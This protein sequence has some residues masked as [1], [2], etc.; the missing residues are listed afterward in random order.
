MGCQTGPPGYYP[1]EDP[2]VEV[3][4]STRP[5]GR[6][7]QFF[8]HHRQPQSTSMSD[9][10]NTSLI[11][12]DVC[13]A[14]ESLLEPCTHGSMPSR[15]DPGP[16]KATLSIGE[17][18]ALKS[19]LIKLQSTLLPSLRQRLADLLTSLDVSNSLKDPQPNLRAALEIISQ[20][21][22]IPKQ[23]RSSVRA[24]SPMLIP[25]QA[26]NRQD[27]DHGIA[28]SYRTKPFLEYLDWLMGCPLYKILWRHLERIR[29]WKGPNQEGVDM[30][31]D[32]NL[33][34]QTIDYFE[35]IDKALQLLNRSDFGVLQDNWKKTMHQYDTGLAKLINHI[36]I[37]SDQDRDPADKNLSD[38]T[39]AS[40]GPPNGQL[41]I[42]RPHYITLL[43]SAIPFV[44]LG[45]IFLNKLLSTPTSRP[46]F[47]IKSRISSME[48]DYLRQKIYMFSC[49]MW[50]FAKTLVGLSDSDS[51]YRAIFALEDELEGAVDY[52]NE[53]IDLLNCHLGPLSPNPLSL[54]RSKPI[55]HDHSSFLI[56][57]FR[58]ASQNLSTNLESVKMSR[59]L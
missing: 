6:F 14:L 37:Q 25:L 47:T 28:K 55:F 35:H 9:S 21:A 11:E 33:S 44:K 43:K 17:I 54:P 42:P 23:I 8:I 51:F 13:K 15:H 39:H 52:F 4:L 20:L 50:L 16:R 57:Q 24:I 7:L 12:S 22:D 19:D 18:D 36:I 27:F 1:V 45:R 10:E 59:A 3:C 31:H 30:H 58:L 32:R 46:P 26:L 2:G 5:V 34:L 48:L 49:Q 56:N 38:H 53:S 40:R 29:S 41:G